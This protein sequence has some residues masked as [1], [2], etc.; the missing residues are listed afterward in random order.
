[1]SKAPFSK[2]QS[3]LSL[4]DLLNQPSNRNPQNWLLTYLDVFVLIVMLVITLITVSDINTEQKP[5]TRKPKKAPVM[6]CQTIA[7][8]VFVSCPP[9]VFIENPPIQQIMLTEQIAEIK[10][11][12][13]ESSIVT[14]TPT[15]TP[16]IKTETTINPPPKPTDIDSTDENKLHQQ[17]TKT[18]DEFGL[19]K[20]VNIKIAQ[21]YAQLEIQDKVLF[22]SSEAA[23]T[24]SGESLLKRLTPLLKQAVGL[25]LIEGHTDNIPIKT[26]QFPSNWELG[27]SRATS[28]LHFLVSQQLDTSRLRAI[29]YADTMPIADNSTPEG[30]EKNRRV[31]ILIKFSEH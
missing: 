20:A 5:T 29:T 1:M 30:R 24:A 23:L 4:E 14:P 22:K 3:S 28:V 27:S 8:P 17:L 6:A 16:E 25:I 9:S 12:S 15:N 10:T 26:A 31:N 2:L 19:N 11:E 13:K 18:I 7:A 21:G